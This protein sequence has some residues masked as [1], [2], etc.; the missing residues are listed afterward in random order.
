MRT[1]RWASA[2]WDLS[3]CSALLVCGTAANHTLDRQLR[4]VGV[5]RRLAAEGRHSL[6]PIVQVRLEKVHAKY[7]VR[8][9]DTYL[10]VTS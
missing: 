9:P 5:S 1:R 6:D 7:K 3:W 10:V 8:W 2:Y 4:I